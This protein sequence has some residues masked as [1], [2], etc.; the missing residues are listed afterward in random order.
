M[1]GSDKKSPR[2]GNAVETLVGPRAVIRGD[3]NFSGGLYVEGTI[4]G[5]V[6]ADDG[7]AAVLTLSEDGRIE[8]EVRAPVVVI[9]G[10]MTGDVYASERVEL[11]ANARV[12]GNIHYKVVEM[13]AG[14]MITGRLIHA[15]APLAQLTGPAAESAPAAVPLRGKASKAEAQE[16]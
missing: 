16:A 5:K 3:I 9:S 8:G 12:Q 4:Y 1:F 6:V 11:A 7:S 15:E 13:A 10:T 2:H 14:A